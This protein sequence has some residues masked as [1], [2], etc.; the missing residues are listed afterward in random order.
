MF[1]SYLLFVH[2]SILQIGHPLLVVDRSKL[3][4]QGER[5]QHQLVVL[6]VALQG[7]AWGEERRG[8]ERKREACER[9]ALLFK[10]VRDIY[11]KAGFD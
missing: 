8:E 10:G 2:T 1:T 4:R 11:R 3:C 6:W 7:R 5:L 9:P